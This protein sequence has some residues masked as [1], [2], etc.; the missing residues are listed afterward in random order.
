MRKELLLLLPLLALLIVCVLSCKSQSQGTK[1]TA[2]S[3]KDLQQTIDYINNGANDMWKFRDVPPL[4]YAFGEW[5]ANVNRMDTADLRMT[6][7]LINDISGDRLLK[8]VQT[9]DAIVGNRTGEAAQQALA[10]KFT[11]MMRANEVFAQADE[12]LSHATQLSHAIDAA[13]AY[14]DAHPPVAPAGELIYYSDKTYGGMREGYDLY[15]LRRADGKTRL[16]TYSYQTR[17]EVTYVV[18]DSVMTR[19]QQMILDHKVYAIAPVAKPMMMIFDAPSWTYEAKYADGVVL[20]SRG[21]SGRPP[22]TQGINEI[23][24]YL[25]GIIEQHEKR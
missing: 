16:T 9:R 4:N 3:N 18:D 8:I 25:K 6:R 23:R 21:E 10:A 1:S 19:V 5:M 20:E 7:R 15:Q 12:L 22:G 14:R 2:L 11:D 24:R 17:G 13:I